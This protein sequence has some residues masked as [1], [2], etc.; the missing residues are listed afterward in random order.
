MKSYCD[1]YF[2]FQ[3]LVYLKYYRTYAMCTDKNI[4]NKAS[5]GKK[6]RVPETSESD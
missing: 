6:N 5:L 1:K 2:Y 3:H 4:V